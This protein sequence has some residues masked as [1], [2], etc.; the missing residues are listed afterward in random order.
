[1]PSQRELGHNRALGSEEQI[2][3]FDTDY[4]VGSF[5]S[6]MARC[7]EGSDNFTKRNPLAGSSIT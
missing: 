3:L 4:I 7:V 2:I 1:M 5:K 6:E